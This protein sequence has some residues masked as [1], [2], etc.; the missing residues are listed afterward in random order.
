MS[1]GDKILNTLTG[2]NI[3]TQQVSAKQLAAIINETFIKQTSTREQRDEIEKTVKGSMMFIKEL[4][5]LDGKYH[6]WVSYFERGLAHHRC[7]WVKNYITEEVFEWNGF[8]L[9]ELC[10]EVAPYLVN[11]SLNE[12]KNMEIIEEEEFLSVASQERGDEKE[13]VDPLQ[14]DRK[15]CMYCGIANEMENIFCKNCG[16]KMENISQEA[17]FISKE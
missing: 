7:V 15:F 10:N 12:T 14:E 13:T 11:A 5:S 2:S 6:L 17:P 1:I 4:D 9:S 8:A 16:K 3:K